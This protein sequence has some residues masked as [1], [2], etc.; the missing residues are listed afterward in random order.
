MLVQTPIKNDID[1]FSHMERPGVQIAKDIFSMLSENFSTI[2]KDQKGCISAG[3][4]SEFNGNLRLKR[5]LDSNAG[6]LSGLAFTARGLKDI[7]SDF[8]IYHAKTN[9]ISF[10]DLNTFSWLAKDINRRIFYDGNFQ[11]LREGAGLNASALG[12]VAGIFVGWATLVL[13]FSRL[14]LHLSPME[15]IAI[16]VLATI[17]IPLCSAMTGY[18]VGTRSADVYFARR[19]QKIDRILSELETAL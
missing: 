17:G 2:D 11:S 16:G 15:S 14:Q 3:Q 12:F 9:C 4:I 5:F 19:M 6:Y 8:G 7:I 18:F 10:A 13:F 1:Y